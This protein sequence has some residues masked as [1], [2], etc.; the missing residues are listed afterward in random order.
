ML[1][2]IEICQARRISKYFL[3]AT[4][5]SNVLRSFTYVW[6]IKNFQL[7]IR[8]KIAQVVT[9]VM[10]SWTYSTPT[11]GRTNIPICCNIRGEDTKHW[12][13]YINSLY[14]IPIWL[15]NTNM[16]MEAKHTK[17]N[18]ILRSFRHE[19]WYVTARYIEWVLKCSLTLLI[20]NRFI[21][22]GIYIF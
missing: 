3:T 8:I 13:K 6:I 7:I 10:I 16:K 15:R 14:N 2:V 11:A 9:A 22:F 4:K 20:L 21:I 1:C 19:Y 17:P 18:Y 12:L 5:K